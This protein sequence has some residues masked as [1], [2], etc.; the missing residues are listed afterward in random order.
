MLR[1]KKNGYGLNVAQRQ[2]SF[3]GYKLSQEKGG[4][5]TWA[6]KL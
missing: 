5:V 6:Q 4:N 1:Q 2:A 3:S